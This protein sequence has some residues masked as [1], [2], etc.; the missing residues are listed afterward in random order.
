MA[1]TFLDLCIY[2]NPVLSMLKIL[3]GVIFLRLFSGISP[4][5]KE[6]QRGEIDIVLRPGQILF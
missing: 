1:I 3:L 2:E 4:K 6:L 5:K